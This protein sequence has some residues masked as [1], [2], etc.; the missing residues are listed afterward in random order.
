MH[1][2][3]FSRVARAVLVGLALAA[4]VGQA[5]ARPVPG[6]RRS[7]GFNLFAG[8]NVKMV[9]N[10]VDCNINNLGEVCVDPTNS[11]SIPGGF[12]PRGTPDQYIFNSGLQL[13]GVIPST[14]GFAW[15]G[16]TVGA[17]FM[18]PRG[19][20]AVGQGIT[21]TYSS[22][23]PQDAANWPYAAY[24]RDTAIYATALINRPNVSQQDMW[25][26]AW[27][28][29][30]SLT[31]GRT[32]PMGILVD[33][34][35]L[36]WN[37]P[38]GNEDILYFVYNFFNITASDRSVYLANL[39]P[40][41][42]ADAQLVDEIVAVGQR[43]HDGV[44]STLGVDI[45]PGGFPINN[46]FAAFFMDPDV[47]D[48]TS[49]YSTAVLPFSLAVAYQSNFEGLAGYT[50]P[51]DIFGPPFAA[52]QGFVGVKYLKSPVNPT[53]GDQYGLT[54]FSNTLNSSTGFPDPRGVIQLWRYLSGNINTSAGDN[55]CSVP[56]PKGRRLCYLSQDPV[57]TRFY[58]S[59]GPFTLEAGQVQTIVVAY[60]H[61]APVAAAVDPYI[62]HDLKPGIPPSGAELV[63][64]TPPRTIDSAVGWL[65]AAD[66]NG[67]GRI[68]QQEVETV[69]RSLLAKSL[70]AQAVFDN[71]FLL[72][73][74]PEPPTFFLVPG[75]NQVTV[76]WEP[77]PTEQVGD[78]YY[79]V[80]GAATVPGPGGAPVA[81]PLFDPDFRQFDVE[82]YRVYRG[83]TSGNMTLIAQ[84]DYET[85]TFVDY[86]AEIDYG[87]C[88]PE[89]GV[90]TECPVTFDTT[91][92]VTGILPTTP[93]NDV[94]IVGNVIQIP[95][96][97][98]VQLA[99]G[100]VFIVKAD[101]AV[102]GGN[103]GKPEL[104]DNGVPFAYVDRGVI[105]SLT[106]FYAV[107]AFD[108]NSFQ[109]GPSS[110][111]SPPV[112]RSVTPRAA[113]SQL[114]LG[115]LGTLE[116]LG[117]DDTQLNPDAPLPTI[118]PATGIFSGPMPPTD[119][120]D[121][122]LAAFISELLPAG[123]GAVS[124][125]VDSIVPGYAAGLGNG[126]TET[127]VTYYFT[128]QGSGAP[129]QFTMAV[130]QDA[131][132]D[133]GKGAS[134]FQAT[135]VDSARAALYGGDRS[136][137]IAGKVS[138]TIPG[139]YRV[140]TYGRAAA[141]GDPAGA[142]EQDGPRWWAGS[143]NEN[144][145]LPDSGYCTPWAGDCGSGTPVPDVT[146][147][148]GRLPG[149]DTL[150]HPSAYIS[151]ASV[152]GRDWDAIFAGVV[153]AADF[154]VYWGAGGLVD[155]VIDVT[156]HVPVPFSTKVRASWG[157]LNASGFAATTQ[158]LTDDRRNDV[159][160][161]GDMACVDPM[162]TLMM[163]TSASRLK[164]G[165]TAQTPAVFSQT[166]E[167]SLI[168]PVSSAAS[169]AGLQ[170]IADSATSHGFMFYLNGHF[171]LMSM[172]SL[173]ASG[174]VWYARFF[175]GNITGY[176]ADGDYAFVGDVR[177]PAVPGLRLS[178]SYTGAQLADT[179]TDAALLAKVHTV[180]DP[181]YVTSNMEI[182]TQRKILKFVNLPSKC[183]IRIYSLS[184][185]LVNLIEHNDP[186]GGGEATWNVR[187][188]N[189]QFVA[190]GVYFYQIETPDGNQ[191]IGRFTV[192]NYAQ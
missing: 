61:A 66:A 189:Q 120:I 22:I 81:N 52:A 86:T 157:I 85:T 167:L 83:R 50:Y 135:S 49:N 128:G 82:G 131:F 20:Q 172:A 78:P 183:V 100:S 14:A 141:N 74:A 87:Q 109:S 41:M 151:M 103:S 153:R 13:A 184:G 84:F 33:Q 122:G 156:H 134:N 152:P 67:N 76:V 181:Y 110:L 188:R 182:T 2:R 4:I 34:R 96:G 72:P 140:A 26:R 97:A 101:T 175:S 161:W 59:S 77:S 27:D 107:T 31:T 146:L 91:V 44:K 144:T 75:D 150:F 39:P 142:S 117:A 47:G 45:P 56:N 132:S 93:H 79:A 179:V 55:A 7:R 136:A 111:E 127:P 137:F 130:Q 54:M 121:L 36:A 30:P 18:D 37:F 106:Y 173:P 21:L 133:L 80:A 108:V 99:D 174:T 48:A 176:A 57:D 178:I 88:A 114:A 187:N 89:L 154:A 185:V 118:D 116:L 145:D 58:Q 163:G 40:W 180:P 24:V 10:R 104:K 9:V 43:L 123:S 160:T 68:E 92:A 113:S 17:F 65:T 95:P 19:D 143:A 148:A 124:V 11:P 112:T 165:G 53:T 8:V 32:H 62:S 149:V 12:W 29:N 138:V 28:G 38:T 35:G 159:L 1:S 147:T 158:A 98:R 73:F 46:M 90:F 16:D 6:A 125:T 171:F 191:K 190:S 139:D 51:P 70:V 42:A 71:K 186:A 177:P 69:P 64:G 192:V 169:T 129:V 162:P 102:T 94:P 25:M 105:N 155:S 168:A 60:V 3:L 5:A 170:A 115:Q 119:G 166:A 15:A 126:A 63:A 164:C 23:D